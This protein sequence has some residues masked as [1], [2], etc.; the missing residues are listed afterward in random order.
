MIRLL[1]AIIVSFT[2][3]TLPSHVRQLYQEWSA[4]GHV[5][6]A[7]LYAPPITTLVLY[8]NSCLNP[9]LYALIS[10]RFR[11]A[12]L[13]LDWCFVRR[14]RNRGLEGGPRSASCA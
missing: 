14:I 3:C 7:D 2:L 12:F 11:K 13:E 5:T 4:R 10:S 8:F 1:V 6:R 9:F